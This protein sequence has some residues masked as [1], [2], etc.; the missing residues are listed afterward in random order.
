MSQQCIECG[1]TLD[2]PQVVEKGDIFSCHDCGVDYV[3]EL[4]EDGKKQVKEL[5]LEE[6]DWGE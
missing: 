3:I 5:N 4:D 2:I 1:G 6:E